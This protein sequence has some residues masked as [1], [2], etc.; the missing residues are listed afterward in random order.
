VQRQH[1]R[2]RKENL[3]RV[4]RQV[5]KSNRQREQKLDDAV[6]FWSKILP[7]WENPKMKSK[8]IEMVYKVGIPARIRGKL[9]LKAIGNSLMITEQLY[10]IRGKQAAEARAEYI[11]FQKA[12]KAEYEA[13]EDGDYSAPVTVAAKQPSTQKTYGK[14]SSFKLIDTDLIRTF[15]SLAFFQDGQ[16]MNTQLKEV[17]D[18]NCFFRPDLGYVQGMSYL[19]GNLLL[20]MSTYDAFICFANILATPLF[21]CLYA[22]GDTI[23]D[24]QMNPRYDICE[25]VLKL[26]F[27]KLARHLENEIPP[28]YLR[29]LFR[30]WFMTMFCSGLEL[31]VVGRIWDCYLICGEEVV[32]RAAVGVL[33]CVRSRLLAADSDSC[34]MILQKN[35]QEVTEHDL[36]KAMYKMKIS[37][38]IQTEI[39]RVSGK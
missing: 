21:H 14:E 4:K 8:M 13:K 1:A 28:M 26:N 33:A 9:W 15:P 35:P 17:L 39:R 38:A 37:P 11:T 16:S 34:I 18:A 32:Y 24:S 25:S 12:L 3:R 10:A 31:D 36:L 30:R 22:I 6:V 5:E 2:Q 29:F 23:D 20:Y 7:D 19:A 27:P